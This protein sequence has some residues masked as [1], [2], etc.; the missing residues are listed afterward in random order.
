MVPSSVSE[1]RLLHCILGLWHAS[2]ASII[3]LTPGE[4]IVFASAPDA[5]FIVVARRAL[6]VEQKP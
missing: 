1:P 6:N 4:P 3:L 2:L 5:S